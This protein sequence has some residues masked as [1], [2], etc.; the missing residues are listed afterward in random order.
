M[1]SRRVLLDFVGNQIVLLCHDNVLDRATTMVFLEF[2]AI[3]FAF[4][5][6]KTQVF[7]YADPDGSTMLVGM[8]K[9]LVLDII[10]NSTHGV[11]P[12]KGPDSFDKVFRRVDRARETREV[13]SDHPRHFEF[14]KCQDLHRSVAFHDV[15]LSKDIT[16]G[17]EILGLR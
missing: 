4:Q 12:R 3:D 15:S 1:A 6:L 10:T 9:E 13:F 7:H 17:V 8:T 2:R 14:K 5:V 16:F 11:I